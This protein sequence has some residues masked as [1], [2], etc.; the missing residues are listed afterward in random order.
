MQKE[1]LSYNPSLNEGSF[2]MSFEEFKRYITD[3]SG[4]GDNVWRLETYK[5]QILLVYDLLPMDSEDLIGILMDKP[6]FA[7]GLEFAYANLQQY[8]LGDSQNKEK[9][10]SWW[11]FIHLFPNFMV[12]EHKK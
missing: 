12:R 8:L 11:K 1:K 2:S 7:C 10:L 3:K 6:Y 4:T 5:D 9:S